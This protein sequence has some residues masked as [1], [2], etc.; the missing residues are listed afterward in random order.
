MA[1]S[2]AAR[3]AGANS[4]GVSSNGHHAA[5]RLIGRASIETLF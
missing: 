4:G 2:P 3:R 5:Y 1:T